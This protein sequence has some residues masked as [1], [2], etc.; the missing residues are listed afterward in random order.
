MIL[1]SDREPVDDRRHRAAAIGIIFVGH[2]RCV[3]QPV[4]WPPSVDRRGCVGARKKAVHPARPASIPRFFTFGLFIT[5]ALIGIICA[6]WAGCWG[7]V[8]NFWQILVGAILVWVALG[9]LGVEK[10][11]LSGGYT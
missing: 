6:L 1:F 2:D 7:D 9:M 8:G 10:C 11:S 3:V 5:M 4:I